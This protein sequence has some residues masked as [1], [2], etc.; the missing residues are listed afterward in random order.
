ML[1]G[2]SMA[3]AVSFLAPLPASAV[4]QSLPGWSVSLAWSRIV[5]ST[6]QAAENLLHVLKLTLRTVWKVFNLV[7]TEVADW[8]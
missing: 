8:P 1:A 6:S 5:V 7:V 2:L 4:R 3:V